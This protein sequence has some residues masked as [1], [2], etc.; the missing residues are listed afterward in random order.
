MGGIIVRVKVIV[1]IQLRFT[2]FSNDEGRLF[3]DVIGLF[4]GLAKK[5]IG[6]GAF[7]ATLF[8]LEAQG[9]FASPIRKGSDGRL[10]FVRSDG[11]EVI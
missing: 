8:V 6:I 2:V 4:Q 10:E 1:K 11:G 3:V 9:F 5:E 7:F